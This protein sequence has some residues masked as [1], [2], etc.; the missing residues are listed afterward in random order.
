VSNFVG[1][2]K[3]ESVLAA[4]ASMSKQLIAE[5]SKAVSLSLLFAE[6]HL[7]GLL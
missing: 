4:D 2:L 3:E 7:C 6:I 5:Q 1:P